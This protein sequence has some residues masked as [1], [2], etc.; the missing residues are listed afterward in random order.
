VPQPAV[1]LDQSFPVRRIPVDDPR[2]RPG[3]QLS[4]GTRQRVGSLDP[5]QERVLEHGA[6]PV[7][8]VR[9]DGLEEEAPRRAGSQRECLLHAYGGRVPALYGSS[10]RS[11][12]GEVPCRGEGD[13]ES[14]LVVAHAWRAEVPVD[15]V[16]ETER[17]RH[18]HPD[19]CH[20][21]S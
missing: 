21:A 12:G 3:A 8:D 11:H 18:L 19:R 17:P 6:G 20:H 9:K 10:N 13:V 1:Q 15:P 5:G 16:V 14:G 4:L 2:R 7:G